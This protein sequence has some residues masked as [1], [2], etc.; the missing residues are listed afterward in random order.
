MVAGP[1]KKK[2]QNDVNKWVHTI[3]T[4]ELNWMQNN[5]IFLKLIAKRFNISGFNR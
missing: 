3:H 1:H 2:H 4:R 5:S